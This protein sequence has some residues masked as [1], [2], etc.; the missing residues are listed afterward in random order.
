LR[1][2]ALVHCTGH[3]GCRSDGDWYWIPSR[4]IPGEPITEFPAFTFLYADLHAHMIAL[5]LTVLA[6]AWAISILLGRWDWKKLG[7]PGCQ[8]LPGRADHW[9]AAPNQHLGLADL[10]GPRNPLRWLTRPWR[11]GSAQRRM[12]VF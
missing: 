11:Y 5:P 2:G 3:F 8:L 10:P 7:S 6:L 12:K 9:R 4:A 1:V